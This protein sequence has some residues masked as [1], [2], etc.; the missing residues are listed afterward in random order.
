MRGENNFYPSEQFGEGHNRLRIVLA[1]LEKGP[2]VPIE[3]PLNSDLPPRG[4]PFS[5]RRG[6]ILSELDGKEFYLMPDSF[7]PENHYLVSV[8]EHPY[9]VGKWAGNKARRA[10]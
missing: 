2:E 4:F 3:I 6:V 10:A 5:L 9:F 1:R 8:D 7:N